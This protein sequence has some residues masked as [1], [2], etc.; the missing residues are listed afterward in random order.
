MK[1]IE[2][3]LQQMQDLYL[4]AGNGDSNAL[5]GLQTELNLIEQQIKGGSTIA[6]VIKATDMRSNKEETNL[7]KVLHTKEDYIKWVGES[8]PKV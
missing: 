3:D 8:F 1:P 7:M 6:L 4:M 5:K 2:H